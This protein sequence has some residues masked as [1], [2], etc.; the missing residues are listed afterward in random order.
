MVHISDADARTIA[1]VLA[2]MREA[3][4]G[5]R[6]GNKL[7]NTARRASLMCRK[8]NKKINNN[9]NNPKTKTK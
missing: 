6:S 8:L 5:M 9:P 2:E 7:A 4:S 3:I 1:Q